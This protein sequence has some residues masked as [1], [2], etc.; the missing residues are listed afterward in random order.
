MVRSASAPKKGLSTG[1]KTTADFGA[2]HL[3]EY[4]S[5]SLIKAD[6]ARL[7]TIAV[8]LFYILCTVLFR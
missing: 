6:K 5:N 2:Q 8:K 1:G 3:R 7:N 4:H